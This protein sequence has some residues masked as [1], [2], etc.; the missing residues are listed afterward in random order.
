MDIF[1]K[2][3]LPKALKKAEDA[4]VS[5]SVGERGDYTK[6][7]FPALQ[8]GMLEAM[9]MKQEGEVKNDNFTVRLM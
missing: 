6:T 1:D 5:Y 9:G 3:A 8:D 2:I 7:F 4:K